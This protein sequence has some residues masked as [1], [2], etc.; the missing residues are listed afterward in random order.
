MVSREGEHRGRST[1]RNRSIVPDHAR[2]FLIQSNIL[3]SGI[4]CTTRDET[5]TTA[6]TLT[7]RERTWQKQSG[8]VN[9]TQ[10]NERL[11]SERYGKAEV[12]AVLES[13]VESPEMIVSIAGKLDD[14]FVV[15]CLLDAL[16]GLYR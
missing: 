7:A 8:I 2:E 12:D 9:Q 1:K 3:K 6:K 10:S 11:A 13:L 14:L 4:V 5:R 15:M 16:E